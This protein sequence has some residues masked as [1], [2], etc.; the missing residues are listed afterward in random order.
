MSK[1]NEKSSKT[2][3]QKIIICLVDFML[4]FVGFW[5]SS[6]GPR[7]GA[8]AGSK[9][10]FSLLGALSPSWPLLMHFLGT[11]DGSWPVFLASWPAPRSLSGGSQPHLSMILGV[12]KHASQKCS[13]C[14]KTTIFAMFYRLR[15]MP[16]TATEHVFCIAFKSFLDRSRKMV[17]RNPT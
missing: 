16:H 13:S 4:I 7:G 12:S 11:F 15:N 2:A 8:G 6:W 17:L 1:I 10:L 9:A 14:N 3:Y 5:G